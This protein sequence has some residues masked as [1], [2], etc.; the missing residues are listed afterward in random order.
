MNRFVRNVLLTAA[1]AFIATGAHGSEIV[2]AAGSSVGGG[3]VQSGESLLTL[4]VAIRRALELNPLL[5][6]ADAGVSS[7]DA[8]ALQAG[9]WPNPELELEVENFGG[10]VA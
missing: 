6:A 7:A 2:S 8:R 4:E 10:A 5:K 9:L 3:A 1:T